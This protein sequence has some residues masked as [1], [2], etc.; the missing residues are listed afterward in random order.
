VTGQRDAWLRLLGEALRGPRRHRH[1]LLAE[2]EEHLDDAVAAELA[3]GCEPAEAEATALR[4]LGAPATLATEWNADVA[5][6]RSA[7]RLR[8]VAVAA[9][10]GAI[11]APVALAQHSGRPQP[12]PHKPAHAQIRP[13]R[14]GVP[15]RAS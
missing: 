3:A 11:A 7:A 5:A 10:V 15:G 12:R 13:E 2:L 14:G 9:L 4:R 1:R 6:R 8:I